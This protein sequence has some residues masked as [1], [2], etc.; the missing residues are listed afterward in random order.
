MNSPHFGRLLRHAFAG[1]LV[2]A[3]AAAAAA[4]EPY[5][6]PRDGWAR[7]LPAEL[8]LDPAK[9]AEAVAYALSNETPWP[10]D[11][12]E[13]EKIFGKL[14]GS[15]PTRRARTNGL[16]IYKGYVVAEFGE[17]T[18]A[19]PT[20]S[21]AKSMLATVA[22]IAVRDGLIADLDQSVGATVT[23]GGYASPQ[24]AKV[25]WRMHLHQDSEWEGSLWGKAHDFVGAAE[26][27]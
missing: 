15:M 20:Y 11:F 17:T 23:D 5:F 19:D 7:R 6:P 2:F 26:Y 21:A 13:Q 9:L 27:G 18:A 24:N 3:L 4:A 25:T 14:L 8:G 1:C 22:G 16:V 10:R 12:S